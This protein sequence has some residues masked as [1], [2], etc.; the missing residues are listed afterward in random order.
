MILS[1]IPVMIS[2]VIAPPGGGNLTSLHSPQGKVSQGRLNC[3][4]VN[5]KSSQQL[6]QDRLKTQTIGS[7]DLNGEVFTSSR[8]KIMYGLTVISAEHI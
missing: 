1:G 5:I 8:E 3:L 4:L 6:A 2:E 7:P